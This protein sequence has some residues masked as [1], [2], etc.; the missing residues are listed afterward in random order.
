MENNLDK[1]A[2][3]LYGKI[4]TRFPDIKIGD[5]NAEVLS[6]KIDIRKA[7]F[8]EF[9]YKEGD[10]SLGI[11]TITLDEDDGIIVQISQDLHEN[12]LTSDDDFNKF[13]RSFRKFSKNRLLNFD[14]QNINKSNLD[15][16]DYNFQAKPKESAIMENRMFGTS[17]ISYQNLGEARLVVKHSQP[18]NT[19][20]AAGRSMHIESIYIE[21]ADGERFKYPYKHLPGAR[22]LA[23]HINHGGNP[24][25][26]I[27]K[28][29]TGL[30]EELNQL[31]KFKGY[32]NRQEQIS[33]AM[34]SVTN[35]VLERIEE[36][37]KEVS[38]LQ[39]S[40]YYK[41]FAESFQS[42][43][44]RLIP[45]DVMNDWVDRLTIRTFNEDLKK[46]F[47]YLYNI[48]DES[49]LPVR[50]LSVDD[51]LDESTV[52]TY[53]NTT[54]YKSVSPEAEFEAFLEGISSDSF[55]NDTAESNE[56]NKLLGAKLSGG[57]IGAEALEDMID[58]RKVLDA[59][60][61]ISFDDK[62]SED[63][64]VRD[65]ISHYYISQK[66]KELNELP[67]LYIDAPADIG[68][69]PAP[70]EEPAP[71][72]M[73]PAPAPA[74][75]AMPPTPAPAPGGMP[76]AP[77]G[78]PPAPGG[79]PMAESAVK[80]AKIIKMKEKFKNA[81]TKGATI[82]TPFS[83]SMTFGDAMRECGINPAECGYE[84]DDEREPTNDP[85]ES[86]VNQLLKII[87]GFWNKLERNFTI[88]GERAKIKVV[89]AFKDGEC[90]NAQEDEVHNVLKLITK[91]DPSQSVEPE[92][93]DEQD[94]VLKLA[95]V[96]SM[97]PQI[98]AVISSTDGKEDKL[99]N[100][101]KFMQEN[102]L[103]LIKRNAGL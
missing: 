100:N 76:P 72:A 49:E 73:P 65:I 21:N 36:V 91:L 88:G 92:Q 31:R 83:E 19:N 54:K 79:M 30:S 22:A 25:D 62:D 17:R 56:L 34:G 86:G 102:E 48:M 68:G 47:P 55:L 29:I 61:S 69:E 81:R 89:K 60:R 15:K 18:V 96:K 16:R 27:G 45:E 38:N 26:H 63:K 1:I 3:D 103:S 39:K 43:E 71:E 37:K 24:Y 101:L 80:K 53:K 20:V 8:F 52:T 87:S 13:I 78:M 75:E 64:A 33:E 12:D 5:E 95:G 66:P 32:V 10:E 85:N 77:G 11:I 41:Q 99:L 93:N 7:R 28:H 98:A 57:D 40:S 46:V 42:T 74:P 58:N 14:V 97:I 67:N 94:H 23:E 4:Q 82:K 9:E 84:D 35:R 2:K 90:P 51:L 6:K 59:I 70:T 44:E 50:E